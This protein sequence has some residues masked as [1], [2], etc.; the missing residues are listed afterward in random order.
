M[1]A[2]GVGDARVPNEVGHVEQLSGTG[3]AGSQKTP[4]GCLATELGQIARVAL[5]ICVNIRAYKLITICG[6]VG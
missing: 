5:D 6:F 4:E 2:D 3:G 1:S